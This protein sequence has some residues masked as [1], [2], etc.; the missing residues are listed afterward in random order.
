MSTPT[1]TKRQH[2][3]DR[4][5]PGQVWQ[6]RRDGAVAV[7]GSVHRKDR[8]VDMVS[9]AELSLDIKGKP[10]KRVQVYFSDLRDQWKRVL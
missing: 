4:V 9:D 10:R 1:K 2:M 3:R 6:R 5:A 8:T 7:I